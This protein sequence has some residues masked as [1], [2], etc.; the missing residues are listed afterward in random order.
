ME[1]EL[2][3]QTLNGFDARRAFDRLFRLAF[4]T[5]KTALLLFEGRVAGMEKRAA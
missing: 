2:V 3:E 5:A 1:V 4:F